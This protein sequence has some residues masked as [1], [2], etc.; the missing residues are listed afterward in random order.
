M[1]KDV[2]TFLIL[3]NFPLIVSLYYTS[4]L[5]LQV[6]SC[7]FSTAPFLNTTKNHLFKSLLCFATPHTV[8]SPTVAYQSFVGWSVRF[9]LSQLI[10]AHN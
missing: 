4:L 7:H 10:N 9:L 2:I 1:F 8:T 6:S 5:P 3:L